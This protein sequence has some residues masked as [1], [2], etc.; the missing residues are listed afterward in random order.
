MAIEDVIDVYLTINSIFFHNNEM[1]V[2]HGHFFHANRVT[3][4]NLVTAVV[5]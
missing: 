4:E 2:T 5:R 1:I 3:K